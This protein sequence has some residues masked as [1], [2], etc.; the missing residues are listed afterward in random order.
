MGGAGWVCGALALAMTRCEGQVQRVT[1]SRTLKTVHLS[2][3]C[4]VQRLHDT[5]RLHR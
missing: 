1:Y 2:S 3:E 4:D 5:T